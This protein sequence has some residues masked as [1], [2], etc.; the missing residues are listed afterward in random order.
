M[1]LLLTGASGGLGRRLLAALGQK[2]DLNIRA[3]V[4]KNL[5]IGSG[6]ASVQGDVTRPETLDAALEGIDTV[7]HLAAITHS[8]S[9]ARYQEVNVEGTGNLL[10]AS[11]RCGV[12]RFVHV[13]SRAAS[14]NGGSYSVGKL[15]SEELVKN[16]GIPWV[17]LRPAEVYGPDSKDAVN[18][19]AQWIRQYKIVPIVGDGK[20]I[21]S[22]VL[23]DDILPAMV[24][25]I[26]NPEATGRSF[27]LGGP[28]SISYSDLIDRMSAFFETKVFKIFLPVWLVRGMIECVLLG[29]KD[30]L[31]RDQVARLLCDKPYDIQNARSVLNFHPVKL[32]EGLERVFGENR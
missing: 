21:L 27:D 14:P 6:C 11:V 19:L 26:F 8:N 20:Q 23:V 28:E 25:A 4:H 15:Q 9:E 22:P 12:K 31:A 32:E 10:A 24:E 7:F 3:L 2:P 18:K 30:F 16:S 29:K 1:N 13:S 17:I 5:N